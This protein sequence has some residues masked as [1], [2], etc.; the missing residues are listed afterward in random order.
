MGNQNGINTKSKPSNRIVRTGLFHGLEMLA[1]ASDFVMKRSCS[2]TIEAPPPKRL[3]RSR[4]KRK[5]RF[6]ET[7]NFRTIEHHSWYTEEERE[8][9]WRSL[10]EIRLHAKRNSIEVKWEGKDWRNATEESDMFFDIKNRVRYHPC[11][12][13]PR[14]PH[15]GG[16]ILYGRNMQQVSQNRLLVSFVQRYGIT[17]FVDK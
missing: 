7:V 12:V 10:K 16:E 3:R 15:H 8:A 2:I 13:T 11:W 1:K 14:L 4:R 9:S 6:N 17:A 5:V